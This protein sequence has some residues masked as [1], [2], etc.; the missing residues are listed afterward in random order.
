[1]PHVHSLAQSGLRAAGW[2][3]VGGGAALLEQTGLRAELLDR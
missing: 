2:T 3:G 1:M